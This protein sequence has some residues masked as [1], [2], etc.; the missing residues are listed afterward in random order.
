M[1]SGLVVSFIRGLDT[2]PCIQQVSARCMPRPRP[3]DPADFGLGLRLAHAGC[4]ALFAKPIVYISARIVD[5]ISPGVPRGRSANQL[6]ATYRGTG[7]RGTVPGGLRCARPAV[8]VADDV[9]RRA[10][11]RDIP[12]NDGR[13]HRRY[14][15][16][17][18][19]RRDERGGAMSAVSA[20]ATF[21]VGAGGGDPSPVQV[22]RNR[23]LGIAG[24][25]AL[26][27]LA[28]DSSLCFRS[29]HNR[30]MLPDNRIDVQVTRF[31]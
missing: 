17:A 13:D 2:A 14:G 6:W 20:L 26:E 23:T 10:G 22:H 24:G 3:A 5:F 19:R 25:V 21:P 12:G 16:T 18:A 28:D 1:P 29:V 8:T 4:T 15:G 11:R 7:T 31:P 27:Y 9:S 30:G